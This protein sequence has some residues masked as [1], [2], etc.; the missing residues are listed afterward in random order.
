MPE[1]LAFCSLAVLMVAAC[2]HENEVHRQRGTAAARF[3]LPVHY[4]T[5][6]GAWIGVISALSGVAVSG[7]IEALH[8]ISLEPRESA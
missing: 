2:H 8:R 3:H 1:P 5:M 4:L 7:I 6:D